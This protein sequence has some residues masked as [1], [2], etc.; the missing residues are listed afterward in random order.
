[1]T[2]IQNDP[3]LVDAEKLS[4]YRDLGAVDGA[5]RGRNRQWR[6]GAEIAAVELQPALRADRWIAGVRGAS[7]AAGASGQGEGCERDQE[8]SHR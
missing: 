6:G 3:I 5:S 7:L 1:M 8:C 2:V 4:T